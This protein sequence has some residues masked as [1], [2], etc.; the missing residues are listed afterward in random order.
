MGCRSLYCWL[1]YTADRN[2]RACDVIVAD[3]TIGCLIPCERSQDAL[4]ANVS[5]SLDQ[6]QNALGAG[7]PNL[8]SIGRRMHWVQADRIFVGDR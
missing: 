2:D 1:C 6:S 7:G 3:A 8:L 4:G 5:A